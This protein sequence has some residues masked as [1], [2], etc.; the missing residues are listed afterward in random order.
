M[1]CALSTFSFRFDAHRCCWA[2]RFFFQPV[3]V[4]CSRPRAV[5]SDGDCVLYYYYYCRSC[6]FC[7]EGT[8]APQC[9]MELEL[10]HPSWDRNRNW[11][12]LLFISDERMRMHNKA[13]GIGSVHVSHYYWV[14]FIVRAASLCK[15]GAFNNRE[16]KTGEQIS[17]E[18]TKNSDQIAYV[19]RCD[20]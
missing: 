4:S 1:S 8:C 3:L 9:S 18:N 13:N 14:V 19:L 5:A 17:S 12:R 20:G 7:T 2:Q 10:D 15:L 6:V 16:K 11:I